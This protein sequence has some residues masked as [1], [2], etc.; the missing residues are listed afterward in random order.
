MSLRCLEGVHFMIWRMSCRPQSYTAHGTLTERTNEW[1]NVSIPV[2]HSVTEQHITWGD[3]AYL[4]CLRFTVKTRIWEFCPLSYNEDQSVESQPK[5]RKNIRPPF[6]G[7]KNKP[8]K[9]PKTN[10]MALSP[11]ANYT[12]WSTATCWRNLVPTFVD[13]G[14]SRGQ[15]G[16]TPTA[17]NLGFLDRNRYFS[18]K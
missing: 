1:Q 8:I 13:R 2:P 9:K 4:T 6:A 14:V 7:S 12:D 15:R 16:G 11:R 10:S 3:P 17:V 5:F 18:F